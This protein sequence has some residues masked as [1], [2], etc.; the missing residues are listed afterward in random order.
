MPREAEVNIF[1]PGFNPASMDPFEQFRLD[2]DEPKRPPPPPAVIRPYRPS[3]DL[4]LVRYLVGASVMEPS[5]LANQYALFTPIPIILSLG[6][7]HVLITHFTAGYP[8]F[9]HN[10]IYPSSPKSYNEKAAI[11]QLVTDSVLLIPLFIAPV[12]A[13]LAF[14][15][16]RHRNLFE[17]EMRR[18]IGEEDLREIKAYYDVEDVPEPVEVVEGEE[19]VAAAA[20]P[21]AAPKKEKKV[22]KKATTAGGEQLQRSGFWVLEYD[23]RLIGA[24]ALDGR[25][26][27]QKLDAVADHPVPSSAGDK[28]KEAASSSLSPESAEASGIE[29]S[30]EVGYALRSRNKKDGDA[31]PSLSVTPPTPASGSAPTFSIS[32]SAALPARTLHLRRFASSLSFRPAGIESDLLDFVLNKAFSPASDDDDEDAVAPAEQVVITLRPSVQKAFRSDLED[33][34]FE[35][36]PR[37]SELE[38]A[39]SAVGASETQKGALAPVWPLSLETRTMVYRRAKWEKKTGRA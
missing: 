18:A 17:N 32:S 14:F 29:G 27:G 2:K 6:L 13:L 20:E 37:G 22:V 23:N 38:V 5:S 36:V 16:W 9:I 10:V 11:L 7:S 33:Y 35:L 19:G 28:K 31:A 25:K 24:V 3:T 8:A 21:A 34:G 1:K 15:E 12:V 4:K 26:P 30:A 39:P